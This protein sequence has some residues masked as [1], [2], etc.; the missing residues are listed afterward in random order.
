MKWRTAFTALLVAFL[1]APVMAAE[2][3]IDVP[4]THSR[5]DAIR[6]VRAEGLFQGFPGGQFRPDAELT[7]AQ[8]VKVVGRL[9]EKRPEL[10]RGEWARI[11]HEG[12]P[13]LPSTI[14]TTAQTTTTTAFNGA[15]NDLPPTIVVPTSTGE[16]IPD[17]PIVGRVTTTS[18]TLP[19]AALRLDLEWQNHRAPPGEFRLAYRV[20]KRAA[21]TWDVD[22]YLPG[23]KNRRLGDAGNAYERV[24]A[25]Q[26]P[27]P[28]GAT[29]LEVGVIANIGA[30]DGSLGSAES[31]S[32]WGRYNIATGE[33]S[34]SV[35][36]SGGPVYRSEGEQ[37]GLPSDPPPPI[38]EEDRP[39]ISMTPILLTRDRVEFRWVVDPLDVNVTCGIEWLFRPHRSAYAPPHSV[40][41]SG[42]E[43]CG[44]GGG[45][46]VFGADVPDDPELSAISLVVTVIGEGEVHYPHPDSPAPVLDT[47]PTLNWRN[48]HWTL[49]SDQVCFVNPDRVCYQR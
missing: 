38:S 35:W 49:W 15:G 10:T 11:I 18:T 17:A 4:D 3:F 48:I 36:V 30:A 8:F 47:R 26:G 23:S 22:Y 46:G 7:E 34:W 19:P 28:E 20:N 44:G 6:Y 31:V 41:R 33:T 29:H 45:K 43:A 13:A 21:I 2:W 25:I 27:I 12:L 14:S 16:R 42:Q 37:V 1:A 5:V 32:G 9:H 40:S 39:T 24:G